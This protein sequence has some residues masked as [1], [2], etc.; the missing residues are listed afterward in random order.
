MWI[1]SSHYG[2]I[3]FPFFVKR[4][5]LEGLNKGRGNTEASLKVSM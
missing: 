2:F 4:F 3:N 5:P 1:H